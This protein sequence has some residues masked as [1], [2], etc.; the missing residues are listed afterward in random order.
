M[1]AE[2]GQARRGIGARSPRSD[3]YLFTVLVA[4]L[5]G[6]AG[7]AGAIVF[8]ILIRLFQG[9]FFGAVEGVAEVFEAGLLADPHDPVERAHSLAVHWSGSDTEPRAGWGDRIAI[10]ARAAVS[11]RSA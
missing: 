4:V 7:A 9:A 5:L 1:S 10:P 3:T 6:F 11:A 8:R 2:S